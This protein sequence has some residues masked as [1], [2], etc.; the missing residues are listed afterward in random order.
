VYDK[1]RLA[2]RIAADLPV[3][4]IPVSYIEHPVVVRLYR[5]IL[6]D[7]VLIPSAGF[8]PR[9]API[10]RTL[11]SDGPSSIREAELSFPLSRLIDEAVDALRRQPM[12]QRIAAA[13]PDLLGPG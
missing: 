13:A 8:R 6:L 10:I 2:V 1:C 7:H 9:F 11:A 3:H 4:E 12:R 5:R